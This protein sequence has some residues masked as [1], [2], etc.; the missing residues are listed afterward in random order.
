MDKAE[1]KTVLIVEDEPDV[2]AFL[3]ATLEDAGFKVTTASNGQDAY[4]RVKE[5]KPDAI[6]LDLVMPR[7]S[8][9]AFYKRLRANSK[10]ATIPVLIITAHARDDLGQEDFNEIMKGKE[11]PPP[12]GYLEKPVEPVDLIHKMADLLQVEVQDDDA[13]GE[14]LAKLRTADLDTLARVKSVLE[15]D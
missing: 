12:Q 5:A 11:V 13:R 14:V 10:F 15:K 4:N 1:D 2:Q 3:A 7:Q 9:V 8:G 6:T